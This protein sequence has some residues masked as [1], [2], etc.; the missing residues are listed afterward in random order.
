MAKRYREREKTKIQRKEALY[1]YMM[2]SAV[3]YI[4]RYVLGERGAKNETER[5]RNKEKDI[6]KYVQ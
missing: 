4:K 3:K 5:K 1:S 2:Y 6:K